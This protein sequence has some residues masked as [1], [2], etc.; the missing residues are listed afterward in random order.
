MKQLHAAGEKLTACRIEKTVDSILG[1][2]DEGREI[3]KIDGIKDF[4]SFTLADGQAWDLKAL[5]K[6]EEIEDL[7]RRQNESENAILSLMDM[8]LMG[9]M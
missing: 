9:G 5:S 2:D 7:K 1:Y 8:S 4:S 3:F 6:E